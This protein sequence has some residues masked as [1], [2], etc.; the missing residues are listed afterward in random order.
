M[1]LS[2]SSKGILPTR[3][4]V[5]SHEV[6]RYS[7]VHSVEKCIY[8]VSLFVDGCANRLGKNGNAHDLSFNYHLNFLGV[9]VDVSSDLS[10]DDFFRSEFRFYLTEKKNEKSLRFLIQKA[11]RNLPQT[12][13]GELF[14]P[15]SERKAIVMTTKGKNRYASYELNY[16][17]RKCLVNYL[18]VVP[19]FHISIEYLLLRLLTPFLIDSGVMPFHCGCCEVNNKGIV[20]VGSSGAG[21]TSLILRLMEGGGKFISDDVSLLSER[22]ALVCGYPMA[23]GVS[24][25]TVSQL[26]RLSRNPQIVSEMESKRQESDILSFA[27]DEISISL[28]LIAETYGGDSVCKSSNIDFV[29]FQQFVPVL[30]APKLVK[31]S[32]SNLPKFIFRA[33]SSDV[34]LPSDIKRKSELLLLDFSKKIVNEAEAYYL[35]FG[36]G[37]SQIAEVIENISR[38]R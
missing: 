1:I 18:D 11:S 3:A 26:S 31:I 13:S 17:E 4:L 9:G 37:I 6:D 14:S 27:E 21:K 36:P 16:Q 38:S 33:R 35:A 10:L 25:W 15:Y 23:I 19:Q 2:G 34:N 30:K 8:N 20:L 32:E 7:E 24:R 28:E 5:F 29:I 22:E 12:V